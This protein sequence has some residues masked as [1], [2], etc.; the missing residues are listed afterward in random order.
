VDKLNEM[1]GLTFCWDLRED[2]LVYILL[3]SQA[4]LVRVRSLYMSSC[5]FTRHVTHVVSHVYCMYCMYVY[6]LQVTGHA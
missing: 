6:A 5:A 2:H 1:D 3:R 4:I